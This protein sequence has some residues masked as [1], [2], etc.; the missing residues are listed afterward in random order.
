MKTLLTW[1]KRFVLGGGVAL[2]LLVA[3]SFLLMSQLRGTQQ[4]LRT[5]EFPAQEWRSSAPEEQ[6]FDSA[7][8]A[9]GLQAIRRNGTQIHSLMIVRN[10]SVIVDAYFYPYDGSIYHD[11]A[12]VTKSLMTTLIGIAADQGE[13]DLDQPMLS[14]FP[15]RTIANRDERKE[16]ITI[17]HLANLT[18]GW[19]AIRWTTRRR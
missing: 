6:G 18:A 3:L 17:R 12:S 11:L 1:D 2:V 9:E 15:D 10:G 7:K 13:L 16:R 5:D 14:F 19:S 4:A 8:L